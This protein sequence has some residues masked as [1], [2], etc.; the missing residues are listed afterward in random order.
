VIPVPEQYVIENF[1]RCVSQP[2]YNK[3]TNTYNG[4]CPFCKEGKS[5]G[6]KTRFFYIPE[7]ELCYCHNCGYSKKAFNF[8]LDVTGKPFN[9]IITEIKK[10]DNT[11]VPIIKEEIVEKVH[12]PSLPDDCIN[13]SDE[14]Q[15]KFHNT[16]P[17][18]SICLN[19]LKKRR[20]NTAINRPKTFYLS[21]TDKV[22]K[23]RLV[24]PFYDVNGDIIHYQTRT[25]LPADERI[26]P[27]YLSKVKSEK[28]LYGVHNIDP[29]LEYVFIFEGPIDSYFIKNGL[30]VCG[31]AEDSSRTFT[32]LQQKQIGQLASYKKIWCLDNQ[33]ND[34]ASL[35]KSSILLD[36]GETIFIWPEELKDFKDVNEYCISKG[37]DSINPEMVLKNAYSGLKG[38]LIL[39][40]IKNK[41]A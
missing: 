40:N 5:F 21:L 7:K 30:A 11:E 29:N 37:L 26:K 19:L 6:K 34:N 18:V 22:H 13:L 32:P 24:L 1:Y 23:N 39:T 27:K 14:N 2:S 25:L 17:V 33:W 41:R 4:S 36:N 31:I 28:S 16:S 10:L 20:L 8:L 38:K 15:L 12:T 3:Y 9:E 35:K